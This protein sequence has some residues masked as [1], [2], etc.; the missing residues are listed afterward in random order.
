MDEPLLDL[1]WLDAGGHVAATWA[2]TVA[3]GRM[4]GIITSF[5]EEK[6]GRFHAGEILL[7]MVIERCCKTG[8]TE[9][10]LGVGEAQY[11]N[12]WCSRTD[13]L[14]D[15]F[16][17]L[18]AAGWMHSTVTKTGFRLKRAAKKSDFLSEL[19]GRLR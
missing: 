3:G 12:S 2:G 8:L 4:S 5:G 16:V 19:A 14:F 18:T 13:L 6:F 1:F 9:F 17:P 11:K 15:S 10:D 7:R